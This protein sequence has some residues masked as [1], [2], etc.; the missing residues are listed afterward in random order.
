MARF[1]IV[2]GLLSA[3]GPLAIDMY[4]PALPGIARDLHASQGQVEASLMSFFLGVT[5]AQPFYGPI[6]DRVGRRPPVLLGLLLYVAAS[7]AC[8]VAT[9]MHMLVAA[10]ALQGLGGGATVAISSAI[11]RDMYTGIQAA[12][13][14]ALRMLVLGVS[15]ILAPMMGAAL[16]AAAPWRG[17]FWFSAVYGLICCGLMF[18]IPETRHKEARAA[19]RLQDAFGVY[20]RLMLDRRFMGAVLTLAFMQFAFIAYIAGSSFV[21]IH[22]NGVQ[23]W[24]YGLIFSSNAVGFIGCA[25]FAPRLMHRFKPEQLILFA[26]TV[27]TVAALIM[28]AAAL[29][30]QATVPVLLAPLFVFLACFGLVGGPSVVVALR[31]HGQISGTASALVSLLQ[32]GA[33]ALG[34]GMVAFL[35]NGTALPMTGMMAVGAIFGLVSA[36]RAFRPPPVPTA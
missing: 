27:Q 12:R 10:R 19:S 23:P 36:R 34:S 32:W 14:M 21:F 1:A 17:V 13:L 5:V 6:S 16:I 20:G 22:M 7:L 30:G 4:L 25:Q 28:L 11:I 3:A 18:L 2:L 9:N 33:A 15:P 24:L 35:A 31:D 26:A 8:S 29:L